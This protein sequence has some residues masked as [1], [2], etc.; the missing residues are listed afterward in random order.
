MSKSANWSRATQLK[1]IAELQ[2]FWAE[3]LWDMH[4]SPVKD[5]SSTAKQRRL[6]F[7]C[8]SQALNGELKYLCWKKFS[9]GEWRTTQEI[10]R[11]HR[12]VHWM[13]S[14]SPLP[15][16]LMERDFD[17]WRDLYRKYLTKLGQYKTGTTSR[18]NREQH[19]AVTARDSGFVSTLRQACI[20]LGRAYDLRPDRERTS[21]ICVRWGHTLIYL[22]ET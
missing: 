13:N 17:T 3:D 15:S 4:H 10:S 11:I 21:G 20:L 6:R 12:M 7:R 16:S 1:L 2:G 22:W 5:L 8:E 14:M 18:M 19:P 9:S